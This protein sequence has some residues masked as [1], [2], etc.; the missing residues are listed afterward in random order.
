MLENIQY[1]FEEN[2][3]VFDN[4]NGGLTRIKYF[5]IIFW[6]GTHAK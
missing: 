2:S 5:A 6:L 3:K 4:R 1:Q